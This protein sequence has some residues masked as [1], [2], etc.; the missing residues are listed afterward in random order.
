MVASITS[1]SSPP[2]D[3][4]GGVNVEETIVATSESVDSVVF[5]TSHV[6]VEICA[7]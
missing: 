2:P 7:S 6:V 4:G 5:W 1:D 3:Y